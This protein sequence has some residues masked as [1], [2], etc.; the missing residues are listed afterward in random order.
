MPPRV[1]LG[2]DAFGFRLALTAA[3]EGAGA[4]TVVACERW[5]EVVEVAE[6][7]RFDAI[8]V[9]LLM[10]TFDVDALVRT[11]AAAPDAVLA[12]ISSYARDDAMRELEGIDGIDLVLTK[13][14]RPND[15]ARALI[16]RVAAG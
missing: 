4:G 13:R 15:I 1:L 14:E 9:D 10:P 2:D 6:A 11:R 16:E 8:L 12:V 7:E 3:L 5:S